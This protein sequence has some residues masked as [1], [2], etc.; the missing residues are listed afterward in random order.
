[1]SP[2]ARAALLAA[3]AQILNTLHNPPKGALPCMACPSV[4]ELQFGDAWLL[5][6]AC[7]EHADFVIDNHRHLLPAKVDPVPEDDSG[8]VGMRALRRV[9]AEIET[10]LAEAGP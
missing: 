2:D 3:K 9:L 4:A 8:N 7:R 1:M 6:Y 10:A 5:H